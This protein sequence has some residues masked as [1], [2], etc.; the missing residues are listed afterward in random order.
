MKVTIKPNKSVINPAATVVDKDAET[1]ASHNHIHD[2][3]VNMK[4]PHMVA[5]AGLE[6]EKFIEHSEEVQEELNKMAENAQ[7]KETEVLKNDKAAAGKAR[8]YDYTHPVVNNIYTGKLVLDES[9]ATRANRKIYEAL[10]VEEDLRKVQEDVT[11]IQDGLYDYVYNSLAISAERRPWT[12]KKGGIY[13]DSTTYFKGDMDIA[14]GV[15]ISDAVVRAEM[16]KA[17]PDDMKLAAIAVSNGATRD[18]FEVVEIT[19]DMTAQQASR[20]RKK[21]QQIKNE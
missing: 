1:I 11:D 10:F 13:P 21:N 7:P 3:D 5:I 12:A 4:V 19:S 20:A 8:D 6:D 14:S 2:K 15:K 18:N 16:K 9:R 17:L